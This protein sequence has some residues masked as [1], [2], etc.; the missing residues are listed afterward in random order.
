MSTFRILLAE[1][2]YRKLNFALSLA[3]V[4]VAAAMFVAGPILIDGYGRETTAELDALKQNVDESA[5]RLAAA[6]RE[7]AA[8]LAHLED[9]TRKLMRDLGFNLML[10]HRDEDIVAFLDGGLPTTDMPQEWVDRLAADKRVT[11]ATH[12]V[13]TLRGMAELDGRRVRI[14]GYLPETPQAHMS[15]ETP[16]GYAIEPGAV[17]LGYRLG[18]GKAAGDTIA[19]GERSFRIAEV[20]PEQGTEEDSR[21]AMHLSDAQ[22]L[23]G[24]P[25]RV[26]VIL[27]L[28]CRC[29]ADA[30]PRIRRQLGEVL[31]DTQVLR[32]VSRAD[33]RAKQRTLVKQKHE[34]IVAQHAESLAA[35]QAITPLVVVAAAL[36]V[37]LM[38]WINVRQ[39]RS[40][41]GVLRAIGKPSSTI[42]ALFLGKAA[43]VGAT[44]A[45]VGALAGVAIARWLSLE[46]LGVGASHVGVPWES[47]VGIVLGAPLL[48]ALAAWLPALAAIAEDPA[49][50]L[51]D[52]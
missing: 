44:G 25:D 26:N 36:W 17:L 6:E 11:F 15:H 8:E 31:P 3:A 22:A 43:L 38:A 27:A 2:G 40:E 37:G 23:L 46:T 50:V 29:T 51:R 52:A 4:A 1:I 49:V 24:K 14:V 45:A 39:R 16:M 12:L 9:E 20:L 30:L 42:A 13:G 33:A 19:L 47:L 21:L 10:V 48:S 7:A 41:I 35:R 18:A 34:Q 28:E 5:R 32:D